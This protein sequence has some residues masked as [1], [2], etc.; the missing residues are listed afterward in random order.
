MQPDLF[1]LPPA[2][3]PEHAGFKEK[4]GTSLEAAIQVEKKGRA[5]RLRDLVLKQLAFGPQ[6]A[7]EI[8]RGIGESILAVRP[9]VSEL[10]NQD[11]I[12]PTTDRRENASGMTARVWKLKG[13]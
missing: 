10:K 6:T 4:R 7:D 12:E 8:A 9:R 5:A 2:R 3:Y 11:K 13:A 1:S